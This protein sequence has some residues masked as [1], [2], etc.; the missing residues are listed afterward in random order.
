M[1][2]P[3][4]SLPPVWADLVHDGGGYDEGY[5]PSLFVR[6]PEAD[7]HC[8]HCGRVCRDAMES[9]C[10]GRLLCRDQCLGKWLERQGGGHFPLPAVHSRSHLRS[11]RGLLLHQ[12]QRQPPHPL[13]PHPLPPGVRRS[14]DH[15]VGERAIFEHLN[16]ACTQRSEPCPHGCPE[17]VTPAE[18]YRHLWDDCPEVLVDGALGCRE[19]EAE[20][21]A[22]KG[23]PFHLR[24]S[25]RFQPLSPTRA[26]LSGGLPPMRSS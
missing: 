10:C 2:A 9:E 22:L 4:P 20:A 8:L 11:A 3:P 17:S 19:A 26:E 5:P 7:F 13:P 25:G 24:D 1:A 6:P 18:L 12:R 16:T 23:V 21:E 15:R 14:A